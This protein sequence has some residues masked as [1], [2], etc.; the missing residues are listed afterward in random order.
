MHKISINYLN[1]PITLNGCNKN[2]GQII[3]L[4]NKQYMYYGNYEKMCPYWS[5]LAIV[6]LS[7]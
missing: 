3:V 1:H 2:K 7:P 6:L 5:F 4:F